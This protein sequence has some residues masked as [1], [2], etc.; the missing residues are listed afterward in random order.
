MA[1]AWRFRLSISWLMSKQQTGSQ[2]RSQTRSQIRSLI[3]VRQSSIHG[4]GVFAVR[5]IPSGTRVIEY[6]GE[7]ITPEEADARYD[8]DQA[9]SAHVLLFTVDDKTFIDGGVGGN[10]ARFINHSCE[11]N[12]EAVC[13]D[14]RIFVEARRDIGR[15]EELTYDYAL[16]RAGRYRAGWKERYACHCGAPSCRG[17]ML[18]PRRPRKRKPVRRTAHKQRVATR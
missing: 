11:P 10:E 4:S 12:C 17:T 5:R 16:R 15:G 13:E 2:T 14:G 7:R 3:E 1:N 18:A 6:T 9:E 8:D